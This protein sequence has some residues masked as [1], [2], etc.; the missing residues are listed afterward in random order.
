MVIFKQSFNIMPYNK[1]KSRVCAYLIHLKIKSTKS[2]YFQW[3]LNLIFVSIP[4]PDET[5]YGSMQN[6]GS[7][8]LSLA[9]SANFRVG[10]RWG[11]TNR[12]KKK[13]DT[14]LLCD[15]MSLH[16]Q[17]FSMAQQSHEAIK[18][19][20]TKFWW[21]RNYTHSHFS[22]NAKYTVLAYTVCSA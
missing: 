19:K 17:I 13:K 18:K 6:L 7:K 11:C 9:Q 21:K 22:L 3:K 20:T 8:I 2:V 5:V 1:I 4:F 15:Q 12:K 10:D 14:S 16:Y